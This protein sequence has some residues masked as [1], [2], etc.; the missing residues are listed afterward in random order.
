VH[1]PQ[2]TTVLTPPKFSIV[3]PAHNRSDL[4]SPLVDSL[5]AQS[6]ADWEAV[7]VDDGSATDH[8][9]A[10]QHS[11]AR[12]GRIRLIRRADTASGAPAS[13]NRG[14]REARGELIVFLDSDDALAPE[15]LA[16]RAR[17]MDAHPAIDFGVFLCRLFRHTPG[18]MDLLHSGATD[19]D[20]LTRYLLLDIPWQTTGPTWR[21]AALERLGP[22]IED[23][24]SWQDW[25]FHIRALRR[26]FRYARFLGGLCHWRI[27]GGES[28]GI[29]SLKPAHFDAQ[30][31][32]AFRV[33]EDL[34][35]DGLLPPERLHAIAGTIL[36][37]GIRRVQARDRAGA[38][39]AWRQAREAGLITSAQHLAGCV[40][41]WLHRV[42]VA[43]RVWRVFIRKVWPR[44]LYPVISRV[45]FLTPLL[46]LTEESRRYLPIPPIAD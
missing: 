26:G 39:A 21:R 23:L 44:G 19:R 1:R 11:C 13:R 18:D 5:L 36:S 17:A 31:R 9:A 25:E 43:G 38:L 40:V 37:I 3:I 29:E 41:L 7:V 4:F 27:P 45:T 33:A 12:D 6:F 35:S 10:I 16:E 24:P 8:F 2:G 15:S 32:V 14:F 28:I 34:R 22:W 46:H 42:P 30:E 20:D